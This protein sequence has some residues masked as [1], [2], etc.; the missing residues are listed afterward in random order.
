MSAGGTPIFVVGH[1]RSGTTLLA[2]ILNAHPH[3]ACGPETAF[4]DL[5]GRQRRR[6][7]LEAPSWPERAVD[8]L[9]SMERQ[10]G[11]S[12]LTAYGLDAAVVRRE[13]EGRPPSVAALLE[14]ITVPYARARG[15]GR[16]V[17]KTPRHL[18]RTPQ[19]RRLWPDAV[20]VRIVRDPRG[21]AASLMAVP[22]GPSSV[23]AAAY[24]W[25]ITDQATWRFFQDDPRSITLRYE[26]L[27]REPER[28][29]RL[30][31]E[32]LGEPFHT[33][34]LGPG[35]AGAREIARDAPWQAR[36][37]APIDATRVEAW[38][39]ELSAADATRVV[40]ICAE[41]M[42]RYGYEGAPE[43]RVAAAMHPLD[44]PFLQDAEGFLGKLAD[45]GVSV[46]AA[47]ARWRRAA[48]ST[49]LWGAPGQL[50]W[51]R[52]GR[53]ASTSSLLRAGRA[54]LAARIRRAP[55]L[56][57]PRHTDRRRARSAF[58]QTG[59]LVARLLARR[60]SARAAFATLVPEQARD[61]RQVP[62]CQEVT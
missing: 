3:L 4:F 46:D 6:W 8:F 15:K 18:L 27:V 60:V 54:M 33:S 1:G 10:H 30:L 35:A 50:R 48:R 32:C 14:A 22:F 25:R 7:L 56:W 45:A 57:V 39:N 43:A 21:V 58:D 37:T 24:Q 49:I 9:V 2:S 41:G 51:S 17:E 42:R 26:D 16:W 62:A 5:L 23:V 13:L 52:G 19:I 29:L 28:E 44:A 55:V 59:D 12:V 47:D 20:I 38:R 36:V 31:C 53:S 61:S 11:G 40:V 34:M